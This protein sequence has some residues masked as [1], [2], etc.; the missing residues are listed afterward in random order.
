M[1]GVKVGTTIVGGLMLML[2]VLSPAAWAQNFAGSAAQPFRVSW[3][4][5]TYGVRP[6]I[7]G[8]VHNDSPF[9]VANVRLRVEGL[10]A[11]KRPIGER[12]VWTLGD[13]PPSNRVYFLAES[14]PGAASYRISVASY[15]LMS[16][17]G[18]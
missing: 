1:K 7:E 17:G 11:E 6:A 18:P 10:D 12:Y 3:A 14:V 16:L 9:W 5:R 13:I 2:T 8:Y 4:P 15:D